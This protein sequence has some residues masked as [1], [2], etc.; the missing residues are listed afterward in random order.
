[1]ITHFQEVWRTKVPLK[2]KCCYGRR[3]GIGYHLGNSWPRGMTRSMGGVLS[4]GSGRL[5]THFLQLHYRK[6]HVGRSEETSVLHLDSDQGRVLP[7]YCPGLSGPLKRL[8]CFTFAAQIWTLWNIHNKQ[9]TEGSLISS[10]ADAIFK[11]FIFMQGWTVLVRQRDIDLVNAALVEVRMLYARL[12]AW[13]WLAVSPLRVF[14]V[15]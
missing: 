1:M 8:A 9:T 3:T 10:P 2:I 13:A 12:R 6:I 15:Y 4:P 7:C 5:W 14:Y 11:M